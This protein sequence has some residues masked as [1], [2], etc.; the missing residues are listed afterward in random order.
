[1]PPK[2]LPRRPT[3]S[4]PRINLTADYPEVVLEYAQRIRD[5]LDVGR[6]RVLWAATLAAAVSPPDLPVSYPDLA[7]GTPRTVTYTRRLYDVVRHI[8]RMRFYRRHAWLAY[9]GMTQ[10]YDA[11][12]AIL[13]LFTP[14]L[15]ELES[16]LV[17]SS[18][19]VKP[20]PILPTVRVTTK[21]P[22][23][24]PKK[25]KAP[26]APK[27]KAPKKPKKPKKRK[28][29][30]KRMGRPPGSRNKPK[31]PPAQAPIPESAEG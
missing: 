3:G 30:K 16:Q 26:K 19:E 22:P 11:T 20:C 17:S 4:V 15:D 2:M 10:R 5:L 28:G 7:S 8:G 9:F 1:V 21:R 14:E 27:P 24:R 6:D 31:A 12:I 18:A 13:R 25:P 23:G 29:P